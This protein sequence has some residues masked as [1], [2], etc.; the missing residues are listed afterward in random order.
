MFD[1]AKCGCE[2]LLRCCW[3]YSRFP[4]N[5]LNQIS[6][7]GVALPNTSIVFFSSSQNWK[8]WC[9]HWSL[10]A[11]IRFHWLHRVS[12]IAAPQ[13]R[14]DEN[15]NR[16]NYLSIISIETDIIFVLPLLLKIIRSRFA[17]QALDKQSTHQL[18]QKERKATKIDSFHERSSQYSFSILSFLAYVDIENGI[19]WDGNEGKHTREEIQFW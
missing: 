14:I 19:Y 15:N 7:C 9:N 18:I 5:W 8:W 16:T 4:V 12:V 11:Q 17:P 6:I 2:A 1:I 13:Q 10:L 3:R